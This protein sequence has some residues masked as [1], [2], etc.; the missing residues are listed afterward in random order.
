MTRYK[1]EYDRESCIGAAACAAVAP[2]FWKMVDDGKADLINGTKN[3]QTGLWEL[4]IETEDDFK[5]AKESADVCPVTVIH[6]INLYTCEKI[7]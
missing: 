7:I 4:I 1:I 5:W 3:E 2:K 6:I